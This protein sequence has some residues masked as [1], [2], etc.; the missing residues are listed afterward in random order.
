MNRKKGFTL[1][2]LLVV[3]SIIG[4]LVSMLFPAFMAVR[5]AARGAQCQNN[6]RQFGTLMLTRATTSPDGR[7]CTGA[8]DSKRDGSFEKFSWVADCVAQGTLPSTMLC[9]GN[10]NKKYCKCNHKKARRTCQTCKANGCLRAQECAGK[11][12]KKFHNC[13]C[14]VGLVQHHDQLQQLQQLQQLHN[15]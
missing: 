1:V 5:N 10:S 13:H 15:L 2:E 6:I 7:F 9:P 8:F 3:I 11:G 14:T 12:G 4:I